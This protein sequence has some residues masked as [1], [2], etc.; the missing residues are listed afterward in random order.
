[1][2]ISKKSR[3]VLSVFVLA[4]L[5]V[6]VM[7][8][9]RNLPLVAEYG[10]G[11]IS[12]F[13]LVALFFLIPC[14]LVSAELATGWPKEGGIYI[15]VREALGD[16]W[17]FLAI[18]IQWA[19]SLPWYPVILSFVASTIAYVFNP[20]LANNP[21][22]VLAIILVSFWG[23]TLLNYL[24]IRTSSL[25]STIGVIVGTIIPG[26]FIITLGASWLLQ[27]HPVQTELSLSAIIPHP[28]NINNLVFLAGMFLAFAGL[29]VTASLAADV[30]DPQRN[31]PRAI[32]LAAIIVFAIFMLGSLSIA[33]VIPKDQITLA[34]GLME[35]FFAFF[36]KYNIEWVLPPLAILLVIGA[37]AEVNAWI[38]GPVKGLHATS[39]H[40]NLP[41]TFQKLNKHD[42]PTSLLLFQAIIVTLAALIFLKMPS[43][44]AGFW[45][46]SAMAAQSYLI[47]YILMFIAAIRLRY[48]K[49][50]VPRAY[51]IP[52]P[53]KGIWIACVVGI[54]ASIFGIIISFVPP[55][56]FATGSLW[57]YEILLILSLFVM[58][59]IP[60]I[61]YQLRK[62][63]WRAKL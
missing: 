4:M 33:I 3:R 30:K 59:G 2:E 46:L 42:T 53:H 61:I 55:S 62:P 54:L 36:Q 5:N 58:C 25:F 17:G 29:E 43:V 31:Y 22:F 16:R 35:A 15:W 57:T 19:H 40:G 11:A 63:Q 44:S 6:S 20:T 34:G 23:M 28:E 27:G 21:Y 49:P 48:T 37:I 56:Q 7:A 32:M 14:A 39:V 26:L 10:L 12:Y 51:K 1:M 41:P 50:H 38:I 8:S 47:M 13:V 60:L 18:W 45:I 9:L 52:Y 24:G